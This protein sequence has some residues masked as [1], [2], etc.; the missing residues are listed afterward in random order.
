MKNRKFCMS[1][2]VLKEYFFIF[3]YSYVLLWD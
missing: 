1:S 2:I 3:H